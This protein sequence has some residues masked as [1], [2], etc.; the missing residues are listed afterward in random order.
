MGT[1]VDFTGIPQGAWR[2]TRYYKKRKKMELAALLVL[3]GVVLFFLLGDIALN[4]A[5]YDRYSSLGLDVCCY[6]ILAGIAV[7][8]GFAAM[9]YYRH[10]L[11]L[12]LTDDSVYRRFRVKERDEL[13]DVTE[14]AIKALHFD[15]TRFDPPAPTYTNLKRF[16]KN[17]MGM[18]RIREPDLA[19]V[20][21]T[22]A[23]KGDAS[24]NSDV[25]VG[26]VNGENRAEVGRILR[27]IDERKTVGRPPL[28][29]KTA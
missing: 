3:L 15:H 10:Y 7:G 17:L 4:L 6:S 19:I 2:S 5:G 23:I 22:T 12:S 11:A 9:R 8:L 1:P 27:A 29:I 13:L 20:V 26:P 18:F 25:I 28:N 21:Y 16:P 24:F 14:N